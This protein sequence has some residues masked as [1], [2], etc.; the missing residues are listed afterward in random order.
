MGRRF[1][2]IVLM[3]AVVVVACGT[4]GESSQ[5]G[6][7]EGVHIAS[8]DFAESELLAEL[9]AQAVESKGIPV[10]RLG[11]V[12]PR[13][14]ARPAL[15]TG[16]IHLIPEYAGTALRFAGATDVPTTVEATVTAL[17]ELLEPVGLVALDPAPAEDT[18]VFV[19]SL[20]TARRLGLVNVSDLGDAGL[21]RLGGPAECPSRPLCL[22]GLEETY[23]V[24][25]DEFVAQP[26]LLFTAE[27]LRRGEI[28]VGVLFSTSP[29]L[30]TP[31]LVALEDDRSLQPADN[32]VPVVRTDALDRWGELATALNAVSGALTTPDLRTLNRRVADGEPLTLVVSEWLS[33]ALP[34]GE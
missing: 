13:E 10:V 21:Q 1:G 18:N 12:G 9:Y 3:L 23:D 26:S 14:I 11:S 19:V 34:A 15:E 28:D 17:N 25:F 2:L 29:E 7:S 33:T 27:A 22:L 6:Q 4:G 20:E 31:G 32:V 16:Q 30:D 24:T 8:F 5:S